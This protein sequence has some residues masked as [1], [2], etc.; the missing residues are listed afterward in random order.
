MRISIHEIALVLK[1]DVSP[2]RCTPDMYH[3]PR[4]EF[5]YIELSTETSINSEP[6][7]QYFMCYI[8]EGYCRIPGI[9]TK[10]KLPKKELTCPQPL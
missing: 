7:V 1:I 10:D 6:D 4:H 3:I 9:T 8:K 2:L 5:H